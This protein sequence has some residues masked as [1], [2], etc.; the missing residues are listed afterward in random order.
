MELIPK[1][2]EDSLVEPKK[3]REIGAIVRVTEDVVGKKVVNLGGEDVGEIQEVVIDSAAG[4]VTY[5]VMSFGGFLGI[6][7]KL[8][9]VP[10][11]SLKYDRS[12]DVFVMNADRDLL[13][14]APGFDKDNWPDMS[15]PTRLS[16][17]YK[18]YGS[19]PYWR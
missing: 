8:F 1:A 2:R 15:D 13:K 18:Y 14:N 17:I 12:D 10:W 16:E 5:A 3:A 9:A 19:K 11:V 6:G 4:R 7:D